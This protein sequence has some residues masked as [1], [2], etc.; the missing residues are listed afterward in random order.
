MKYLFKVSLKLI[1]LTELKAAVLAKKRH[2]PTLIKTL[3]LKISKTKKM[4][5]SMYI[6]LE[7][8]MT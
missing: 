1:Q 2:K 6:Q 5:N 8:R 7:K 4:N 3:T